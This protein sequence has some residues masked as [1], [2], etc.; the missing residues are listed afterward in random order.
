MKVLQLHAR[1]RQSGGEDAVVRDEA[2]LLRAAG[3]EVIAAG[4][5][6]PDGAVRSAV[7]LAGAAWNPRAAARVGR[8]AA[9]AAPDV[10]HV[11]NTW[12]ALSPAAVVALSRRGVPVVLTVHNWRL[13]CPGA[14]LYTGGQ[15]C[16]ECVGGSPWVAV[17][18]RCY[19]DS[20]AQSAVAAAT[21]ALHRTAGT[22][23]RHVDRF[24]TMT[25]FGRELLVSGGLPAER[26]VVRPHGVPDPGPRG[27]PPSDSRDVLYVGR[28]TPEK[29]VAGLCDWWTERDR[30]PLRLVVVGD[31][32]LRE[33]LAAHCGRGH[34]LV[35]T[36][37]LPAEQ[38]RARLLAARALVF[39]S[40]WYEPFGRVLVEALAAGTPVL[41]TAL[42]GTPDVLGED[43]GWLVPV[44]PGPRWDEALRR[45]GDHGAVDAA[46]AAARARYLTRSTPE[47]ATRSLLAVYEDAIDERLR[48][49][50]G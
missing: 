25:A 13:L 2:A 42:G 22:W 6:N 36:G 29:G 45:I 15:V 32:P 47:V 11:H 26:V 9:S 3:H 40:R 19:R 4:T 35:L 12:Y 46:G 28:L 34:G 14:L 41:G 5:H 18:H 43:T 17:R 33:E 50:E 16:T 1:Y 21:V 27:G 30:S 24:V 49:S 20:A 10:A 7:A 44:D 39:P 48:R 23:R 38:V 37:P 8:A 31:G